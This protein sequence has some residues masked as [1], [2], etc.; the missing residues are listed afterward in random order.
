MA[1]N[2]S[3]SA[4]LTTILLGTAIAVVGVFAYRRSGRDWES[5][6][7]AAKDWLDSRTND[8]Q[9]VLE[10]TERASKDLLASAQ[11]YGHQAL[12][13]AKGAVAAVGDRLN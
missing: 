13:S 7:H 6:L 9:S 12:G 2:S 8:A 3:A 10:K 5:D 4:A 11:D 1:R